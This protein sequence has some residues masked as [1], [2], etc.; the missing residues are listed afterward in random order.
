MHL[1][2]RGLEPMLVNVEPVESLRGLA[3]I[4]ARSYESK[5]IPY[6][7]LD[8]E[9][10]MGWDILAKNKSSV[11]IIRP[12]PHGTAL[13]DRVWTLLYRMGFSYLSGMKGATL[14]VNSSY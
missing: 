5:T 12:K 10:A 7:L 8:A 14:L 4:K 13:E 6:D 3:R 2:Q 1:L 9:L 11:R